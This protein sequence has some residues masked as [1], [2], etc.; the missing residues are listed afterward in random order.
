MSEELAEREARLRRATLYKCPL[1]KH[2]V[3]EAEFRVPHCE[4]CVGSGENRPAEC[5]LVEVNNTG[6]LATVALLR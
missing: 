2:E 3:A 1:C 4:R 5:T 6:G